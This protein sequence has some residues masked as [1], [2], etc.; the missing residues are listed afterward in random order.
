MKKVLVADEESSAGK[1]HKNKGFIA[2]SSRILFIGYCILM[3]WEV[4]IGPYRSTGM[5]R[6]YNLIPFK[7]ISGFLINYKYYKAETIFIN[8]AG[9]VITFVPLGFFLPIVF[10]GFRSFRKAITCFTLIILAVETFQ[11]I[12]NVGV[13][14]VDDIILNLLGCLLGY[15]SILS[16]KKIMNKSNIL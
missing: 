2:I 6:L 4:F 15:F 8:L 9:N 14:D 5:S 1:I 12:L 11:L 16:L 13:F 3:L 7:T 10:Q